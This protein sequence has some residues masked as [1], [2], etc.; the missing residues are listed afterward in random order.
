MEEDPLLSRTEALLE[1][2]RRSREGAVDALVE[3][4]L[5]DIARKVSLQM[6]A[7]VKERFETGDCVQD[8]ALGLVRYLP[9]VRARNGEMLRALLDRMVRNSLCNKADWL[10]AKREEVIRTTPID[11][12]SEIRLDPPDLEAAT[13]SEMVLESERRAWVRIAL[14]LLDADDQELVLRREFDQ[15][16]YE[17]IGAALGISPDAARMRT[18]RARESLAKI[19]ERL[20][21]GDVESLVE[22]DSPR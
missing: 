12:R 5:P 18:R 20:Q 14:A 6:G 13:P 19:I 21:K 1:D 3:H 2:V 8:V 16:S 7:R 4:I 11:G 22:P 15:E 10:V 17:T 9:R